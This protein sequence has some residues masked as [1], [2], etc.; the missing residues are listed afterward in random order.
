MQ[1]SL[2]VWTFAQHIL[3]DE[4]SLFYVCGVGEGVKIGVAAQIKLKK[5][6]NR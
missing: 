6:G 2:T 5:F 1:S 4:K 3:S